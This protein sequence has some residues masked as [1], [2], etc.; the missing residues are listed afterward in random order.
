MPKPVTPDDGG[1]PGGHPGVQTF[2][3]TNDIQANDAAFEAA[4]EAGADWPP[5]IYTVPAGTF[6]TFS[7]GYKK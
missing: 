6:A 7:S 5:A 1:G 2:S 4:L 3:L